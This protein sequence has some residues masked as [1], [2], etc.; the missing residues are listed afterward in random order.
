MAAFLDSTMI[1]EMDKPASLGNDPLNLIR[2]VRAQQDVYAEAL[3]E[4]RSGRKRS[5]WMWFIFP[6]IA[7]LGYSETSRFYALKNR[8]EAA[9]YLGHPVLGKR[10][11][12]C[13]ETVLALEGRSALDIFG[14]PDDMKLRSCATLFASVLTPG[15]VFD[16]LVEKY[17]Q[18]QRD[19]K[20]L[21]LLGDRSG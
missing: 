16:R 13:A 1:D 18:G 8:A 21:V 14:H 20:T 3:K 19:E 9:A 4:L 5:H 11:L 2:F 6:Q 12:E 7:G 17:F 10:L 15:S